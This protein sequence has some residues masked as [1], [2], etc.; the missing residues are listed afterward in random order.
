MERCQWVQNRACLMPCPA[1][2]RERV[3][4]GTTR[5]LRLSGSTRSRARQS[6]DTGLR[7]GTR[8]AA[9]GRHAAH[10][11]AGTVWLV[12]LKVEGYTSATSSLVT[13]CPLCNMIALP[14]ASPTGKEELSS[15]EE[16]LLGP[17]QTT[18]QNLTQSPQARLHK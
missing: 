2:L 17:S 3:V 7:Q 12:R 18:I 13:A 10:A 6:P 16:E 4:R 9:P 1:L 8:D 15:E 14:C 5:C 11:L